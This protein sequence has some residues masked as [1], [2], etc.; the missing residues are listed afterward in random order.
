MIVLGSNRD[1]PVGRVLAGSTARRLAHGAPCPVAV[2]PH[3][4]RPLPWDAPLTFGVGLS[5]TPES[6]DALALAV[7]LAQPAH[8]RLKVVTVVHVPPPAHPMFAAT[9]VGYTQWRRERAEYARAAATEAI[10]A[11]RPQDEPEVVVVEG[12][13]V[14]QLTDVSREL[15]ILV[16]GSRGYGPVRSVLLGGV[17][18]PL[19]ERA[20]CPVVIVPRGDARPGT[21]AGDEAEVIAHA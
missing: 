19:I 11:L 15:D 6:R 18:A 4:W 21:T 17:S 8:A 2:A 9:S 12:E 7:R 14:E 3:A 5:D 10:D 1:G 13:P 16:V 20:A